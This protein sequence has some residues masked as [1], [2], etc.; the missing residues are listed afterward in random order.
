MLNVYARI[1]SS[2]RVYC[3]FAKS[4]N[5]NS[6]ITQLFKSRMANFPKRCD[7]LVRQ[8]IKYNKHVTTKVLI[9]A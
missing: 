4:A 3:I 1:P 6:W 8:D 5:S 9:S 2:S 7:C